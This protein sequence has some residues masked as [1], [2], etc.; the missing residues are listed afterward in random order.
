MLFRHRIW[1]AIYRILSVCMIVVKI[2]LNF[3]DKII[4]VIV[5][6]CFI[7]RLVIDRMNDLIIFVLTHKI[8]SISFFIVKSIS[9]GDAVKSKLTTRIYMLFQ[10]LIL[11]GRV[12]V[13][14]QVHLVI[15]FIRRR[16][17]IY[18]LS[19]QNYEWVMYAFCDLYWC[20]NI[21]RYILTNFC[22]LNLY[23]L[24]IF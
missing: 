4:A 14:K 1:S 2:H 23:I 21:F 8:L 20:G 24:C 6:F 16:L 3:C 9:R 12:Q 19:I 10:S 7:H 13:F 15:W 22:V 18:V 5:Y 17:F 11:Y